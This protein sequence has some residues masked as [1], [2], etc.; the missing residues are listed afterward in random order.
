M[1]GILARKRLAD[2]NLRQ[3][4]CNLLRGLVQKPLR[5]SEF[6]EFTGSHHGYPR[7]DLCYHRQTV[8]NKRVGKTKFALQ[9]LQQQQHL[10]ANGHVQRGTG[11]SAITSFGR[12]NTGVSA[13]RGAV[14]ISMRYGWTKILLLSHP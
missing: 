11:S 7:C 9:F 5:V 3:V 13:F 8:R 12:R 2:R 10:R 6:D 4:F 14:Q 1:E